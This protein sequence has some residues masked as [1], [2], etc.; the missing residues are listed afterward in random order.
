MDGVDDKLTEVTRIIRYSTCV[1]WMNVFIIHTIKT[2]I[3]VKQTSRISQVRIRL[4]FEWIRP[5]VLSNLD[6]LLSRL[7]SS[8][9]SFFWSRSRP[10]VLLYKSIHRFS[11]AILQGYLQASRAIL[12][13]AHNSSRAI[14]QWY[15]QVLK[16]YYMKVPIDPQGLFYGVPIV[17][18]DLLHEGTRRSSRATL[19][20]TLYNSL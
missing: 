14:I 15:S 10:E 17:P 13:G 16:T 18:Q 1:R 3:R 4:F 12:W 8:V 11:K 2:S 9:T 20:G 5:T 19:L 6:H 7:V